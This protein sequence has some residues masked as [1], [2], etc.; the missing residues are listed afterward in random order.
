MG[1]HI[2]QHGGDAAVQAL[3]TAQHGAVV[4]VLPAQVGGCGEGHGL[5]PVL[6]DHVVPQPLEQSLEE[7]VVGVDEAGEDDLALQVGDFGHIS[8][9]GLQRRTGAHLHNLAALNGDSALEEHIALGIHGDNDTVFQKMVKHGN[10]ALLSTTWDTPAC[11][12]YTKKYRAGQRVA[13][14]APVPVFFRAVPSWRVSIPP[15]SSLP[16]PPDGSGA[17]APIQGKAGEEPCM[18]HSTL[19]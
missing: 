5:Q 15:A 12:A 2:V 6:E 7:V 4:A 18:P 10:R 14:Y 8:V 17:Q 13:A 1:I 19:L 16:A 3:H 11:V 9:L